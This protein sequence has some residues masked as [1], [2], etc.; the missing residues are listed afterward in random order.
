[1]TP[2]QA[3]VLVVADPHDPGMRAVTVL[4]NRIAPGT[5]ALAGPSELAKARWHQTITASGTVMTRVRL[6][7]GQ[8]ISPTVVWCT[9]E[10]M[11]ADGRF[12]EADAAYASTEFTAL[13]NSWLLSLGKGCVNIPDGQCCAGPS[14]GGS[15][16][17]AEARR[18]GLAAPDPPR[19]TSGRMVGGGLSPWEVT[20]P[21]AR[22]AVRVSSVLVTGDGVEGAWTEGVAES[23]LRLA[24]AAQC[25]ILAVDFDEQQRVCHAGP[26]LAVANGTHIRALARYLAAGA[27]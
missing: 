5:V 25:R 17:R 27:P 16:W 14:W 20:A 6:V 24:R 11:L 19:A 26:L 21:F 15:R 4:A 13:V 1:V 9:V 3:R 12:S 2:Q 7:S 10:H 22:E 8:E 18:A 23:C